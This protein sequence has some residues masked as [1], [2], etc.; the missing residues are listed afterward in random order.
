MMG[1]TEQ[2]SEDAR[3]RKFEGGG[4]VL[5]YLLIFL[6]SAGLPQ[7][8]SGGLTFLQ[9]LLFRFVNTLYPL[10]NRVCIEQ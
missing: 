10:A 3:D 8:Y 2:E 1:L 4:G 5:L 9:S 6:A 7:C